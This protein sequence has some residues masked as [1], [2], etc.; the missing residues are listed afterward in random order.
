M[1]GPQLLQF[2]M[3]FSIY[4][5]QSFSIIKKFVQVGSRS[6][7]KVMQGRH[8]VPGQPSCF[9]FSLTM[10]FTYVWK[11]DIR[12]ILVDRNIHY[13]NGKVEEYDFDIVC[14]DLFV[15]PSV[16][17]S[18]Q[19]FGRYLFNPVNYLLCCFCRRHQ[20]IYHHSPDRPLSGWSLCKKY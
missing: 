15:H 18:V 6:K 14:L 3:D 4:L 19:S 12:S 16:T 7:V 11:Y 13:Y 20:G 2:W 9:D 1:S 8:V 10:L 5:H 17:F